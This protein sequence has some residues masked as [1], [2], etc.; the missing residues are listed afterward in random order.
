MKIA[1]GADH[2]GFTLK[3]AVKSHLEE[4]GHEVTDVG[5]HST[6]RTDYPVWGQRT[7]R[8]VAAGEADF[9]IIVCGSG[10]GISI[11]ANKVAGARCVVCTEPYSAQ[12]GR[13]H[14]N[15][16]ML[17]MGERFV[18]VDMAL[19]IVDAFLA[20]EFE[21]GRHAERVSLLE[22]IEADEEL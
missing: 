15:A 1:L 14:N 12:M 10:I 4:L 17:A 13:R 8:I 5:T 7:A 16:N 6:D 18:G 11:A 9:G 3:D 2:A 21:G 19:A 20:A 22:R